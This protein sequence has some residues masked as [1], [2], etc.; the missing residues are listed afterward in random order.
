MTHQ[1]VWKI[2]DLEIRLEV[3]EE[4]RVQAAMI[5]FDAFDHDFSLLFGSREHAVSVLSHDLNLATALG[6]IHRGHLVGLAGF[7]HEG[8]LAQLRM[9]TFAQEY[10]WLSGPARYLMFRQAARPQ[11][12]GELLMDGIGVDPAFRGQGI[13]TAL[14]RA[15]CD[16]AREHGYSTIRL[17]VVD[18]NTGARRLYERLGFVATHTT[19]VLPIIRRIVGYSALTTMIKQIGPDAGA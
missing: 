15:L 16:F 3:P 10:N 2:D 14:F 9:R 18:A 7:C 8:R 5:Y 6:A 19:R 13:G 1:I 11:H 12:P 17:D 4:H